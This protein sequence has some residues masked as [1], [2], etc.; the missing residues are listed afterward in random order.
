MLSNWIAKVKNQIHYLP[1]FNVIMMKQLS[2]ADQLSMSAT[3]LFK[4]FDLISR[5]RLNWIYLTPVAVYFILFITGFSL[6]NDLHERLMAFLTSMTDSVAEEGGFLSFLFTATSFLTWIIIKVV[7]FILFGIFSGYLTLIVLAPLLTY[8]T[9][10]A[11]AELTGEK[12]SFNPVRFISDMFRAIFIAIRNAGIQLFWTILLMI[13]S[14]IPGIN[15][16]T[17]PLLFL[18]T[19]YFYGFSFIDYTLEIK[20]YSIKDSITQVR[21][22]KLAAVSLGTMFLLLN[23]I[24]WIGPFLSTFFIFPLV[25]SSTLLINKAGEEDKSIN[26]QEGTS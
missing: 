21:K 20:G 4:A 25:I 24:P 23:L 10:K 11:D 3:N 13:L 6:T 5:I 12:Q 1:I 22:L 26:K 16:F 7:I 17:A 14:L 9:E 2:P 19:A 18:I 8:V 15:L